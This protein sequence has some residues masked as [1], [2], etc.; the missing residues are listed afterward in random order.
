MRALAWFSCG[1]ASA[2]AAK[3]MLQKYGDACEVIYCDTMA[4]EHPDNRRFF[5]D[6][7]DWLGVEITVIRSDGYGTV[8]DVFEQTRY[9]A[10]VAGARCTSEMKKIPRY[11]Y[12]RPDDIHTFG[13]TADERQRAERFEINNPEIRVDWVLIENEVTKAACLSHIAQA[14]I[15][16]PEMYRLGYNNNNCFH[17]SER[18]IT[19]RGT[20][21]FEDSVDTYRRVLTSQGFVEAPVRSFGQ[22]EIWEVEVER[23]NRREVIKTT[24]DHE[25]VVPR[26]KNVGQGTVVVPTRDLPIGK[27]LPPNFLE[28][29]EV[30]LIPNGVRHGFVFGDGSIYNIYQHYNPLS[31]ANF[32]GDKQEML[33][34]FD[35]EPAGNQDVAVIHGL[36]AEWSELPDLTASENYK[37]SF[38]AGLIAADGHPVKGGASITNKS[39]EH[40]EHI[41]ELARSIGWFVSRVRGKVRDTNYKKD[42]ELWEVIFSGCSLRDEWFLRSFHRERLPSRRTRPKGFRIVSVVPTGRIEPVY[43]LTV[44]DVHDFT[45]AHGI[46]TRNCIGCVKATSAKYWNMIRRDF[47]DVFDR[48][49]HQSRDLDVR[50]TRVEGDRVYLDELPPDYLPADEPDDDLSCG[51][52]CQWELNML[53]ADDDEECAA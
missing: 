32:C 20:V 37:R 25:W 18:F 4:T 24:A 16:L 38:L 28:P 9:M 33:S 42:A 35:E 5:S 7:Q 52:D 43:C 1:A 31:R 27:H 48:R 47:P 49:A 53:F 23:N 6:V 46:L 12:Q 36:P 19:D 30:D 11:K 8:D 44:P 14:G 22:Q 29:S 34:W 41:A 26:Y 13:F 45:L 15:E 17:G 39:R 50:L 51:P 10:G 21:S 2:V 40:I 3:L